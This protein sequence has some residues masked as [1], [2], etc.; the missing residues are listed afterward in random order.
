MPQHLHLVIQTNELSMCNCISE[1]VGAMQILL[2]GQSIL[3]LLLCS[4]EQLVVLLQVLDGSLICVALFVQIGEVLPVLDLIIFL[5]EASHL[6]LSIFQ[7]LL[8]V[9]DLIQLVCNLLLFL[10]LL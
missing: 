6:L 1:E 9:L 2:L 8:C 4:L 5:L 10:F 7:L 3:R